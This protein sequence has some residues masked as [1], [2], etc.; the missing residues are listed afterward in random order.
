VITADGLLPD[1]SWLRFFG[2]E[3]RTVREALGLTLREVARG[4]T[5][6]FQQISNVEAAR[7][8]PSEDLA[9]ELDRTLNTG[10]RFQRILRRV[11]ADT[12]PNWF[13]G[14][15][16]EEGRATQIR[17][18]QPCVLPGLFQTEEYT[19][20]RLRWA[21]P[22]ITRQELD[23]A[24]AAR[25][26]RQEVLTRADPPYIWL[27]LDEAVLHRPIGGP[28]VMARQLRRLTE[29]AEQPGVTL[30]VVPLSAPDHPGLDGPFTVWS[31]ADHPDVVHAGPAH[32]P[33]LIESPHEVAA[34]AL[35]HSLLAAA[36]LNPTASLTHIQSLTPSPATP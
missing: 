7:R 5:Y 3:L 27:I 23:A 8:T 19:R 1:C 33:R 10:D 30:Q 36:A 20:A 25:A 16:V 17:I 15:S 32:A 24:V 14:V 29:A 11:L 13:R 21:R 12:Y 22:G 18:Y 31:Y 2:E 4:T 9:R 35:T 34:T 6:S 26:A 28:A